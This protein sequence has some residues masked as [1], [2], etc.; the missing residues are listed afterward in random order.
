M[1]RAETVYSRFV[2]DTVLPR[3][4]RDGTHHVWP[5]GLQ[6]DVLRFVHLVQI[7]GLSPKPV[8]SASLGIG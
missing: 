8:K 4:E 7:S 1:E 5:E 2:R 3:E 6:Q